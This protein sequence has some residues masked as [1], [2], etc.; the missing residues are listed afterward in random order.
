MEFKS[1]ADG[2]LAVLGSISAETWRSL[3]VLLLILA[4]LVYALRANG[5]VARVWKIIQ[6][7]MLTNW[8]LALLGTAAIVLS[9]ASGWRTWDGMRNF[10][11]EPLLSLM[12]TFGIQAVMLIVA[13]LIGESFATGMSQV[14]GSKRE[15]TPADAV[16]GMVLGLATSGAI[17]YW[18]LHISGAV[19]WTRTADLSFDWSRFATVAMYFAIALL[20]TAAIAYSFIRGGELAIPYVRGTRVIARN[21]VL[22]V[23]FLACMGTSVFFSFDSF[24]SV[25]FPEEQRKRAADLRAQNQVSGILSDIGA[26]IASRRVTEAARLFETAEWQHYD[27]QLSEL[28]RRA[29]ASSREIEAYFLQQLEQRRKAIAEQQ[30]RKA[31]AQSGQAGLLTRKTALT[32]ELARARGE[33]PRLAAEYARHKSELDAK[34]REVDEKR[35]EALAE[36]RGV[37]GTGK[38][39][40]GPVYRQRMAELQRL[41]DEYGIKEE[42]TKDAEKRLRDVEARIAQLERELATI[43]GDLAKLAS[44]MEAADQLIRAAQETGGDG[45]AKLDPNHMLPLFAQARA[46]FRQ[47]PSAE[48]LATVEQLCSQIMAALASTPATEERARGIDCS[49][50]QFHEAAAV[51]FGLNSGLKLFE[52]E[53]A[54]GSKL[55]HLQSADDLFGFARKCLADSG[56]PSADTEELRARINTAEI[57]RDDKAHRFVVTLNAFEDGNYLAYLSLAIAIGL[58]SLIFLAGLF[59]ANAVRSPLSDIPTY[60]ARSAQQLEAIIET[61]LIPHRLET[62]RAVLDAMR[63]ITPTNGFTAE[64][65]IHDD[66][67]HA[68]DLLRVM[69]AG[70]T[71]GA[72]RQPHPGMPRYEIRAELFEYLSAVARREFEANQYYAAMADMERVISVALLPDIAGNAETVLSHLHPI[73]EENGYMAEVWMDQVPD[74]HALIVR[75]ALNAGATFNRVIRIDSNQYRVHGD[76]YRVLAHLRGR[77]LASA[78]AIPQVR[79]PVIGGALSSKPAELYERSDYQRQITHDASA[80]PNGSYAFSDDLQDEILAELLDSVGIPLSAYERL[81]DEHVA[82]AALAAGEALRRMAYRNEN[83]HQEFYERERRWTERLEHK[84]EE[85]R[86]RF[87]NQRTALSLVDELA[88]TIDRLR[89]ALL[90]SPEADLLDKLIEALEFAAGADNLQQPSEQMLLK[91]LKALQSYDLADEAPWKRAKDLIDHFEVAS[92]RSRLN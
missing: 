28:T 4:A 60:K 23:M 10:T 16:I 49:P 2:A 8:Q 15:R 84:R 77:L 57:N 64:V 29:Q 63:P 51:V 18:L 46:D 65:I 9:L 45:E 43:D 73:R 66:D 80:A 52:T 12:I 71:I 11:N 59:G 31:T 55:A 40:R 81:K 27:A 30:E 58:D 74:H 83:L 87:G 35:V 17:F 6:E 86:E 79:S 32:E 39:G 25:I 41:Q 88:T 5:F 38:Q 21:V 67:P 90:L 44:E 33:R 14:D 70:A 47:E 72:V 56:L 7:V 26:T 13:W 85:L 24:F 91:E 92:P 69:N 42:R 37:E 3:L 36:E 19:S 82:Q 75:S 78:G 20:I 34:A 62:A 89:P 50:K 48:K 54:G 1:V 68:P 53:C 76:F 61:A 22:W